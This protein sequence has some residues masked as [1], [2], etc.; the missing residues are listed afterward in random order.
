MDCPVCHKK[1]I[2]PFATHC[3]SCDADL[4][5]FPI[6][7]QLEEQTM[8]TLKDKLS[9]EGKIITL[10]QT[11]LNEKKKYQRKMRGIYGLLC[12]LPILFFCLGK[13]SSRL[14]P[15]TS[16]FTHSEKQNLEN[17][18]LKLEKENKSLL[19]ELDES[20]EKLGLPY[21]SDKVFH[22]VSKGETL[23]LLAKKYLGDF[24]KWQQ[25]HDLN[26][27]IKDYSLLYPGDSIE[28]ILRK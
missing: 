26:P 18:I 23:S 20:R 19:L 21:K 22:V 28:I 4:V 1:E 10:Q 9:L 25:I 17:Q 13:S 2:S 6:L 15:T 3:P 24:E 11:R 27:Q 7:A 8:D 14:V 5:A 16:T 12:L